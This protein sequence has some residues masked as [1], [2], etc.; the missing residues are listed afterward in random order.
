MTP[1]RR[2]SSIVSVS[3]LLS[4]A[5]PTS[6]SARFGPYPAGDPE[7]HYVA[8]SLYAR[9]HDALDA[10]RHLLLGTRDAAPLLAALEYEWYSTDDAHTAA[11]Y[12]AR[13]VL[14]YLLLGNV[15]DASTSL[16]LFTAR[17][18]APAQTV[19]AA[20]APV[21][22]FPSLPLVNFLTLLL[23]A[24]EKKA[25]DLF[26]GLRTHYAVYLREVPAWAEALDGIAE[27]YFGIARPRQGNPLMD[28][29]GS[30]F[31][32]QQQRR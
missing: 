3:C 13:A 11:Q 4:R 28:M 29:M 23:L 32:A 1:L 19:P 9:E 18:S 14:P 2:S 6:W 17:L 20:A 30:M 25:A 21:K 31:G 24:L 5:D 10:E 16:R 22:V 15:R 12:A 8:G 26:R 7:L 27:S